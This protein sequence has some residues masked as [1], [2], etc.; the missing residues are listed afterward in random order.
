MNATKH[1]C[2]H[3]DELFPVNTIVHVLKL[4]AFKSHIHGLALFVSKYIFVYICM[5]FA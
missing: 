2:S 3:D 1:S 5:D 4:T